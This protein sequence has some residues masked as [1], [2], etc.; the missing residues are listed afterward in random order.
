M[1]RLLL[2]LAGN[3][4]LGPD[5]LHPIGNFESWDGNDAEGWDRLSSGNGVKRAVA[6]S[7]GGYSAGFQTV[8]GEGSLDVTV[9]ANQRNYAIAGFLGGQNPNTVAVRVRDLESGHYLSPQGSWQDAP[10]D[11]LTQPNVTLAEYRLLNF[12]TEGEGRNLR[13]TVRSLPFGLCGGNGLCDC[14]PGL[15]PTGWVDEVRLCV[16]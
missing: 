2:L 16:R 1:L 5:L 10:V 11:A 6:A 8:Y 4:C 9:T 15:C 13:V 12:T 3:P 7:R 14:S